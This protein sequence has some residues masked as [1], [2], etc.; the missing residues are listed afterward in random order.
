MYEVIETRGTLRVILRVEEGAQAPDWDDPSPEEMQAWRDG[1]VYGWT[2]QEQVTW[3]TTANKYLPA[4]SRQEWEEVD[5]CWGI[6]GREYAEEA[7]REA[8]ASYPEVN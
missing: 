7:A 3:T 2:V 4:E 5:S 1:E 6:Y 8:L